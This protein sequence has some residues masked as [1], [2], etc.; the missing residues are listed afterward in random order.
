MLRYIILISLQILLGIFSLS[1]QELRIDST[2]IENS[3]TYAGAPSVY[4]DCSRCDYDYIRTELSFVNYV[5]D[6][7]MADIHVFVTDVATAGG[8]TEYQFSFIGRQAFTG[9]VF[10]LNHYVNPNATSTEERESLTH[11]LKMGLASYMLQT[12]LG[13]NF[14]VFFQDRGDEDK[15]SDPEDPWDFWIFQAYVGGVELEMESNQNIFDSRWGIF[16][17]RVTDD[18][19]FR[20]RPYFNYNWLSIKT[21]E[22]DEP[23]TST[24]RRHGLDSYAIMSINDHWSTGIFGTYYTFNRQNIRHRIRLGPGIEYSVLPYR[25]ATRKAITFTYQIGSG[26]YNYYDE[27]IYGQTK[28]TLFHHGLRGTVNIQQPW[29]LIEAGI[30][31]SHYLHDFSKRRIDFYGLT[32]VRLFEGFSLVFQVEY[33]V[34]NDQIYLP[35]GEASLEE[36][37]L[38]QREL[39]TDF[40]FST[41]VA[42]TYTFGSRYT[43]IVNTRFR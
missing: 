35:K 18:W 20:V 39:A 17:D 2:A 29:G 16:A 26:Y 9:T 23:V 25:M 38:R 19:K 24:Q 1:G 41:S 13:T 28:E 30:E 36:V 33:D 14:N 43:N 10:T 6:P 40:S 32:S 27:T 4:L 21:A 7:D 22:N 15:S 42:I 12:D 34:V 11:F 3:L 31:G 8:G 37:L 5:R